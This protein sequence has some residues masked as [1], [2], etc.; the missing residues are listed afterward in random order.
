[1]ITDNGT[2]VGTVALDDF[3]DPQLWTPH[4]R[5]QPALYLHRLIVR[6]THAGL[7]AH[8]RLGKRQGSQKT[9]GT[10]CVSTFGPAT[11]PCSGTTAATDSAT[12]AP[13]TAITPP[14]PYSSAQ[15]LPTMHEP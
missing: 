14:V 4:E 15:P 2:D 5:S 1:M 10:G 13:S 7:G 12:F 6:R 3:A 9:G 8:P 11:L